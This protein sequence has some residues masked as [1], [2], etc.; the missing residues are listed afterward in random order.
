MLA[1]RLA[2]LVAAALL[3]ADCDKAGSPA[4]IQRRPTLEAS[5]SCDDLTGKVQ[6]A[7]VRQMRV[8]LDAY[9]TAAG[10]ASGGVVPASTG[11]PASSGPPSGSVPVSYTTTNTHVSG[12]DEADFMKN[13][14]TRIFVLSGNSL[15]VAKS[16]PPQDLA[17]AGTLAIEGWPT[18]MFLDGN[19]VVVLSTMWSLP[20]GSGPASQ[21]FCPPCPLDAACVAMCGG[22]P[23]TKT[24]I[25]DVSDVASPRVLGEKYLSGSLSG[26]RRVDSSMRLVL[27]DSMRWPAAV[28]WSVDWIPPFSFSDHDAFVAAVNVLEDANEKIIRATPVEEFFP[29]GQQKLP[30]GTLVALAY[31]CEDFYVP[32]APE[33]PG[34]LTIATV[35]L[36]NPSA[37]PQRTSVFGEPGTV[38]ATA[39][40]LYVASSHWWWWQ[41]AGQQDYTYV[42]EFDISDPNRTTYA[43]SGGVTGRVSNEFALDELDGHLRVATTTT[44]V[45]APANGNGSWTFKLGNHVAVLGRQSDQL[46]VV[47]DSGEL[48]ADEGIRAV[49]FLGNKGFVVTFR[50]VDPLVTLDLSDPAKPRKVAE[51]T[52]PGFSTYLESIDDGHLLAI[53]TDLPAPD[54][55]TGRVDFSRR[56]MQLSI[57]D[58]SDLEHPARTAQFTTGTMYASSEAAYDHHAFNWYA[59]RDLFAIPFTDWLQPGTSQNWYD[60]FVS[61]VRLFHVDASTGISPLGSLG[62]RDV[63]IEAG[64]GNWTY[65]YVPWVRRSVLAT[66]DLGRDYVYAVS[67]AGIRVAPVADLSHP[68]A[69]VVFPR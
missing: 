44:T 51:L 66:D 54:P 56:A 18:S 50:Q 1:T 61:D 27:A 57:F 26:A 9:K 19:T 20:D 47:G 23:V 13:D 28:K 32:N 25:V 64:S 65:R 2:P 55:V 53:G 35:D 69:T 24:T 59:Q 11:G 16:W 17:L 33:L 3:L 31:R 45:S 67:D 38:Y 42:H 21:A 49:R 41:A 5:S 7:A 8:R 22:A 36:A 46:A 48:V 52:I 34:L 40:H 6:D 4:G 10:S 63:Y 39:Q 60:Q 62:M 37:A 58:V 15:V 12:V 68:L 29:P 30:D 43:A 14:G